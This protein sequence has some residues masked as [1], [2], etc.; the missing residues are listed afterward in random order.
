M[1][2]QTKDF[3]GKLPESTPEALSLRFFDLDELPDN[4]S[5]PIK[6]VIERFL[7]KRSKI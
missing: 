7:E 4:L 1:V 3:S 2:Y 6:P 5:P